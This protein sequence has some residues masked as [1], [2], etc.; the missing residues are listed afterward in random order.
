LPGKLVKK[1]SE[2]VVADD[3]ASNDLASR[4]LTGIDNEDTNDSQDEPMDISEKGISALKWN[5]KN[6]LKIIF[7]DETELHVQKDSIKKDSASLEDGLRKELVRY[8]FLHLLNLMS[9]HMQY[10]SGYL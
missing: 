10:L 3:E 1:V 9:V 8:H 6:L 2:E 5:K 4:I 7:S